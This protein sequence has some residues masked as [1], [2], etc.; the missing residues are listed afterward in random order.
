MSIKKLRSKDLVHISD[1]DN[2]T[3]SM[4]MHKAE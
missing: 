2:G 4:H 3:I 1:G